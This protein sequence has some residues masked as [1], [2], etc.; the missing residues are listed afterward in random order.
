MRRT[1]KRQARRKHRHARGGKYPGGRKAA[2]GGNVTVRSGATP[3]VSS[4][5]L[6]G[7]SRRLE[8]ASAGTTYN[9]RERVP[10]PLDDLSLSKAASPPG[11]VGQ[12]VQRKCSLAAHSWPQ[13]RRCTRARSVVQHAE[14]TVNSAA[15]RQ[16]CPQG[17]GQEGH[18]LKYQG[19]ESPRV[20]LPHGCRV[21]LSMAW[22]LHD[23]PSPCK[24][25]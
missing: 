2:V 6:G 13:L 22:T 5:Q 12:L 9:Q 15:E 16:R 23:Q 8:L 7:L 21:G 24:K 10:S 4:G 14:R 18:V 1:V 11:K 20:S 19:A 3:S 17:T 25:K